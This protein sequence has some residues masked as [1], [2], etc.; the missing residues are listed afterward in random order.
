MARD[1]KLSKDRR[2]TRLMDDRWRLILD[3]T[4]DIFA[5]RGYEG[6][7]VREIAEGAQLLSGSLYYYIDTKED[8]LFA[9]IS[10]FHR[11]GLEAINEVL[12]S[13]GPDAIT[14]LRAVIARA[15]ELNA[16][17]ISKSA[18]FF[19]EFRHLSAEKKQ[20]IVRDRRLHESRVVDLIREAQKDGAVD[21]ALDPR[22]TAVSI[23]SFLNATY[24]WYRPTSPLTPQ[25]LGEFQ[26]SL[27]LNGILNRDEPDA[28][29]IN[30]EEA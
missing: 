2:R 15:G 21:P 7:G 18:V 12:E 10:D 20:D 5:E 16:Q 17:N 14:K 23:L 26:A 13:T 24:T 19:N 27:L 1:S 22:L 25:E 29:N 28:L 11:V 9:I 6:T 4:A 3:A 8:L 30:S